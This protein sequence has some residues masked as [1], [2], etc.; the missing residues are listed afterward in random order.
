MIG[1]SLRNILETSGRP[2]SNR[3]RLSQSNAKRTPS[4][5]FW[6]SEVQRLLVK[7]L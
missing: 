7:V 1:D 2:G 5:F 6:E 4:V 3:M